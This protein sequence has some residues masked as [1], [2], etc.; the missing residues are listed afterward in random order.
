MQ[1]EFKAL[2][3]KY[4]TSVH[5]K[6]YK[7]TLYYL[8]YHITSSNIRPRIVSISFYCRSNISK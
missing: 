1:Q 5:P 7:H 4:N 2:E 8:V 6:N 3:L